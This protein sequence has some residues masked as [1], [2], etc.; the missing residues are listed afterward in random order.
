MP[1]MSGSREALLQEHPC[2]E[3]DEQR[4][5]VHEHRRG[6]GVEVPLGEVEHDGVPREPQHAVD[7]DE[8]Q[9]APAW[10]RR[11]APHGERDEHD[12]ADELPPEGERAGRDRVADR[13][14]RDERRRPEHEHD[15]RRGEHPPVGRPNGGVGGRPCPSRDSVVD[16]ASHG[17]TL[18]ATITAAQAND[19]SAFIQRT[20]RSSHGGSTSPPG[21]PRGRADRLDQSRGHPP[22]LHALRRQPARQR[23]AAR[24]RA[25]AHREARPRHRADGV[26]H[27]RRRS[28]DASARPAR[29]LRFDGR[30]P[31][32]GP[33]RH[34]CASDAS[35]PPIA[36]GCRPWS[37]RSS[38]SSPRCASS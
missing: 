32:L 23:T 27:R 33:Q 5:D 34:R 38:T 28:R 37:P 36:R 12:R 31:A 18:S 19:P 8:H 26:R 3:R 2:G 15:D 4:R 35:C 13:A 25:D 10:Q 7:R 17:S 22:R 16:W 11:A 14:D 6:A 1:T 30:R 21:L 24:D 20:V 9:A 29:R